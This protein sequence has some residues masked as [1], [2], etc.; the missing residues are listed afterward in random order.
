MCVVTLG[1]LAP[2][3]LN[4]EARWKDKVSNTDYKALSIEG[5]SNR[6]RGGQRS[7][8]PSFTS[9]EALLFVNEQSCVNRA[10]DES[11]WVCRFGCI[12]P[13]DTQE[14][15]FIILRSHRQ[16]ICEDGR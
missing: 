5:D 11:I 3:R 16:R 13:L 1:N 15:F 7:P 6:G 8:Q 9:E 2:Q 10:S 12:V 14:I 4:E